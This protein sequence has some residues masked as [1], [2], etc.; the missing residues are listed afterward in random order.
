MNARITS[1][2]TRSLRWRML[3]VNWMRPEGVSASVIC[4]PSR[5]SSQRVDARLRAV[6]VPEDAGA[7]NQHGSAQAGNFRGVLRVDAAIYLQ[8]DMPA[9]SIDPFTRVRQFA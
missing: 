3:S 1:V 8:L 2:N 4:L 5:G 6:R 7:R 9:G